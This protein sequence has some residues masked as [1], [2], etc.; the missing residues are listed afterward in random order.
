MRILALAMAAGILV[1]GCSQGGGANDDGTPTTSSSPGAGPAKS[2]LEQGGFVPS[3]RTSPTPATEAGVQLS[4]VVTG[5]ESPLL[6]THA[7]DG[8]GRLFIVE[9]PGRIQ[10]LDAGTNV[11]RL[12]AD[13]SARISTGGNEQGL[14]G[15]AFL[16]TDPTVVLLSYTD[17]AG[18]SV[19]SRFKETSGVLDTASEEMLLQVAQPFAN[20]NGGHLAFGPDGMLYFGLGDGGAA[21]D[22]N[23]NGQN[24]ATLLGDLLRIGVAATGAYCIPPDNPYVG[25]PTNEPEIWAS[26]LRNPWRFS[27]DRLTGDLW[28]GDVGQ[29]EWEEID[30]QAAGTPGGANYG[31][32]VYEGSYFFP[33]SVAAQRNPAGPG[34]THPVAEYNHNPGNHCSVTGGYVYRG[35]E[36]KDLGGLYVFA[37][38][39]SGQVWTMTGPTAPMVELMD[40]DF[41]VSSF[42]EDEAGELYLASHAEGAVYRFTSGPATPS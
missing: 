35:S 23:A 38:Y 14:L 41:F 2:C 29:Q 16:P 36:V 4:P 10:V 17:Q 27:F 28:I 9:Q 32:N 12:Y 40:T 31:W 15:M 11:S 22:P 21:G 39:C 8:S 34:F 3:N 24:K 18:E 30:Y 13:V 20:H 19:V 6:V 5:L 7:G 1:A 25:H 33:L 42:G 26:G 37:D